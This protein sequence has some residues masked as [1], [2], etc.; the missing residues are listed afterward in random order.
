[1]ELRHLRFF[2]AVVEEG[3]FTTAAE[4]RLHTAQPSLS[5][6]IRDLEYEVGAP[7]LVRNA[8]GVDPTPAG[9][10]FLEHAR[11]ALAQVEAGVVAA[12][13]AATPTKPTLSLGFLTG[14]EI[15]WLP[16][17]MR[18]LREELP[19]IE[20]NVSSQNS[21]DLGE[22]L[23][24]GKLDLAFMRI[25]PRFSELTFKSVDKEPL[26]VLLPSDHALAKQ[27]VVDVRQLKDQI[28]IDVGG[29]ATVLRDVIATYLASVDIP[30]PEVHAVD[31]LAMGISLVASTRGVALLPRY[32]EN[33]LPWSVVS[34]PLS[35]E[36]PMIDLAVAYRPGNESP[37]LAL[38]LSKLDD[39]M[40][41]VAA[42]R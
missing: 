37:L 32:V 21:P 8:R 35:G 38:L 33:F 39:L 14:H 12:R 24:W 4:R 3:S 40:D 9:K 42:K 41:R 28:L 22:A 20:V 34:R 26:V 18:T 27:E 2:V 11:L 17:V 30:L 5:R 1:M 25:E 6:Q 15:D 31:N 29:K 23:T 7:L 36:V 10:A 16:Q 19:N 13:R